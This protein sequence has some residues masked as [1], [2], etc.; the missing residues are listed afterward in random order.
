MV[1]AG[2]VTHALVSNLCPVPLSFFH[3]QEFGLLIH[4]SSDGKR[5]KTEAMYCPARN[6]EREMQ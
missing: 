6:E 3:F 1:V 5:S 4:V 2:Q